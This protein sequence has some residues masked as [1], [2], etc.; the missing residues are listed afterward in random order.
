MNMNYLLSTISSKTIA[1]IAICVVAVA[2]VLVIIALVFRKVTRSKQVAKA[3]DNGVIVKDNTRYSSDQAMLDASQKDVTFT[4]KDRVLV[5]QKT[6]IIG[7]GEFVLPGKY[8]ILSAQGEENAFNIR[9][10]EFVREYKHGAEV[11]LADGEEITP[12]SHNIILR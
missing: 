11:V 10:G 7:K 4:E 5:A 1:I 3:K 8:T 12:I 6:Y 9:I 2:L